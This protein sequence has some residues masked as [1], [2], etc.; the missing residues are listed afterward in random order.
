MPP[1]TDMLERAAEALANVSLQ[2]FTATPASI[3]PFGSSTQLKW[4]I[5]RPTGSIVRL[6]L[7]GATISTTGT[8]SV[9]P[10]QTTVY[11][12]VAKASTLQRILGSVTVNVDTSAC[13]SSSIPESTIQQTV[14]DT[15]ATQLPSNDQLSQRSPATVEVATNGITV[16]LRL[17][18]AI[19][20]FADP[21]INVDFRFTLGVASGQAIVTIASFNTDVSW[22]WWVTVVTLGVSQIVEEIVANR[23]E[24]GIRPVLQTRL[25][26]MVDAQLAAL[27]AT[28]R[29]HA[30]NTST[31]Q[32]N[33]TVCPV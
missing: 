2:S 30:L 6:F 11:R 15:I 17:Q 5:Q 10:D 19:N 3:R 9:S 29:L 21:D 27:P 23:I 4:K 12:I 13:L 7:Q 26:A 8:R 18:A 28:H 22:P 32:I 14:R 25:K 20:N 33:F 1:T 16:K 24:K 31:D